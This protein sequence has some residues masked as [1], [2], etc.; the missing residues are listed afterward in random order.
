MI[1]WVLAALLLLAVLVPLGYWWL[2]RLFL[3][4]PRLLPEGWKADVIIVLGCRARPDGTP[5]LVLKSRMDHAIGL[6]RD[7]VAPRL[8]M[9]GAA[10]YTNHIEAEV[11]ARYALSQGV[12]AT[13]LIAEP[14]ATSTLENAIQS[15]NLMRSKGWTKGVLVTTD[16]HLF[17]AWQCFAG[18]NLDLRGS[19]APPDGVPLKNRLIMLLWESYLIWRVVRRRLTRR[20]GVTEY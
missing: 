15:A 2:P 18:R 11:M 5:G 1:L 3:P 17:R 13:A 12:P 6:W 7:G 16:C 8:L 19:G 4:G 9:S 10:V 20:R 14:T